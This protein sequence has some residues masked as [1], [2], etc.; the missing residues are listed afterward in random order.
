MNTKAFFGK[1][2]ISVFCM[3]AVCSS[4]FAAEFSGTVVHKMAGMSSTGKV[5]VKGNNVRQ[6]DSM[7]PMKSMM[8]YNADKKIGWMINLTTK[9][10]MEAKGENPT[11]PNSLDKKL[12]AAGAKKSPR[13]ET[14]NGYPCDKYPLTPK[15][16]TKG[17]Q[18]L[19][20]SSKLKWPLKMQTTGQAPMTMEVKNI[21]E[22]GI[23]DSMFTLPK[24]YKKAAMPNAMPG[25][26]GQPMPRGNSKP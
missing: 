6:E 13:K 22:G 23:P 26:P 7:G 11:D 4:L 2:A 15:D 16:K 17:S 9:T 12:K 24:G 1:V 14:I 3:F 18:M 20:V 19:W 10:Y 25:G 21:K 8:I 5:Y